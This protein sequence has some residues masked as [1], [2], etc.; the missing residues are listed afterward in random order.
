MVVSGAL[1]G[2]GAGRARDRPGR[3]RLASRSTSGSGSISR[4]ASRMD[5][6]IPGSSAFVTV[7]ASSHGRK[8]WDSFAGDPSLPAHGGKVPRTRAGT[9]VCA[10]LVEFSSSR[11]VRGGT[12]LVIVPLRHT[13]RAIDLSAPAVWVSRNV[14][15]ADRSACPSYPHGHQDDYVP[16][17]RGGGPELRL[18]VAVGRRDVDVGDTGIEDVD[19]QGRHLVSVEWL[20]A[21]DPKVRIELT[22]PVSPM[23]RSRSAMVRVQSGG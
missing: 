7:L 3:G 8:P 11:G 16:P 19:R 15:K 18:G 1:I 5:S 13:G 14:R 2:D 12:P 20:R 6:T 4:A 10:L 22:W 21:I 17:L 23:G 9:P